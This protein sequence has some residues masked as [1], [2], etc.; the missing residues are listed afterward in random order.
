MVSLVRIRVNEE[1]HDRNYMIVELTEEAYL[2]IPPCT[3]K[4]RGKL[5]NAVPEKTD[6]YSQ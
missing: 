4:G 3:R 1:E 5:S 6:R 2:Q